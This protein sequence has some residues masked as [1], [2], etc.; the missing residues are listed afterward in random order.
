M[1]RYSERAS[2]VLS[3]EH[4]NRREYGILRAS[5]NGMIRRSNDW[6]GISTKPLGAKYITAM[7]IPRLPTE[8]GTSMDATT[9]TTEYSVLRSPRGSRN[10]CYTCLPGKM[11][12][13][14]S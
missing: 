4:K 11:A 13:G 12:R 14:I 8:V 7:I 3:I 1:L 5:I 9:Y 6:V 2:I 10:D